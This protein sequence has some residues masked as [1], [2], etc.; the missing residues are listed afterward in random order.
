MLGLVEESH[1]LYL[2]AKA[3]R[4]RALGPEHKSFLYSSAAAEKV[5]RHLVRSERR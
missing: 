3:G 1:E 4:M 2:E 5:W